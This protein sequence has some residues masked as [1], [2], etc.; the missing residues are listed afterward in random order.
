M[1]HKEKE[2]VPGIFNK[3]MLERERERNHVMED[4]DKK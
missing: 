3:R 4:G 2:F 1:Y